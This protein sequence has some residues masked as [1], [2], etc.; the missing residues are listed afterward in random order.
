M[1]LF[2]EED[3]NNKLA[4]IMKRVVSSSWFSLLR[5]YFN[6]E[7]FTSLSTRLKKERSSY[8]IVPE[9]KDVFSS[10]TTEISDIKVVILKSDY[11]SPTATE[12]NDILKKDLKRKK[13]DTSYK[14]WEEQGVLVL[15]WVLTARENQPLSHSEIGWANFIS[16]VIRKLGESKQ[17]SNE[18]VIFCLWGRTAYYE[19]LLNTEFHTV[20]TDIDSTFSTVNETLVKQNKPAIRW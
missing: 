2:Q 10:Y 11:Y 7:E 8:R 18:P 4:S 1:E 13:L 6:K 5:D 12:L 3:L 9:A 14:E 15:D 20:L 17:R 19:K 16:E